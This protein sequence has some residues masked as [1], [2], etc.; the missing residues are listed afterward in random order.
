MFI[1]HALGRV[2][3]RRDIWVCMYEKR[4]EWTKHKCVIKKDHFISKMIGSYTKD[5]LNTG[6]R[7][8]EF[9]H[10]RDKSHITEI[11]TVLQ[12]FSSKFDGHR[13]TVGQTLSTVS[14]IA[15]MVN[16]RKGATISS[17]STD[18]LELM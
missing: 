4:K 10:Y 3:T 7:V 6:A 5:L 16:V 14:S 1:V 9:L 17:F 15:K 2:Y 18:K 8:Q 12:L 13:Y 11:S